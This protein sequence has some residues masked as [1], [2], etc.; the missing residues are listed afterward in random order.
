LVNFAQYFGTAINEIDSNSCDFKIL[1]AN[2]GC[3]GIWS[4]RRTS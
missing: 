3:L 1:R 2:G 4:R